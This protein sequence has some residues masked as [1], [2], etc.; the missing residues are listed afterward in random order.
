[1]VDPNCG[2]LNEFLISRLHLWMQAECVG[3]WH[4]RRHYTDPLD[5][6]WREA[7]CVGIHKMGDE[8]EGAFLFA[9]EIVIKT[10]CFQILFGS[11]N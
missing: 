4:L 9:V 8:D 11:A 2:K 5:Q 10:T 7:R 1:M 6:D 3:C